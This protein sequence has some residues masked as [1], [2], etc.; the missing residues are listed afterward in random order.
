MR[1]IAPL[2][3]MKIRLARRPR[4]PF[5]LVLAPET[6]LAGQASIN[7]PSTVKCSSDRYGWACRSTGVCPRGAHV[8][9]RC[10]LSLSPDSSRKTMV[11]PCF[12]AF[13]LLPASAPISSGGSLSRSVPRH[14]PRA[15]G[16]S[17]P[18]PAECAS[19]GRLYTEP[20]IRV[21]SDRPPAN[22][23]TARF[24]IP[25][26]PAPASSRPRSGGDPPH[27][28]GACVPVGELSA[29]PLGPRRPTAVPSDS[30]TADGHPL[31]G[32]SRLPC[33][34]V[35]KTGRPSA[36][37]VLMLESPVSLRLDFPYRLR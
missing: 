9:L 16:S 37:A 30:P 6:L 11:R 34:L 4:R 27:S 15:A 19:H 14:V 21:R 2:L 26:L 35:L 7:V 12:W 32:R 18:T 28:A 17:L 22:W 3:T 36:A 31:F 33:N 23:S 20:R 29:R 13:F 24:H 25:G 10:G 1:F 5:S 8:R